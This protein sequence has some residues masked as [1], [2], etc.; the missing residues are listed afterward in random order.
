MEVY[1]R[2][3]RPYFVNI[4]TDPVGDETGSVK[5]ADRLGDI[6]RLRRFEEDGEEV[7]DDGLIAQGDDDNRAVG[8]AGPLNA[9]D[10]SVGQSACGFELAGLDAV[11][12]AY[13]P[14]CMLQLSEESLRVLDMETAAIDHHRQCRVELGE[15]GLIV[16]RAD[17]QVVLC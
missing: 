3:E 7:R 14:P 6:G 10:Q 13:L 15:G 5:D 8:A 11:G 1:P 12:A 16:D 17:D 4:V 9:F 2:G